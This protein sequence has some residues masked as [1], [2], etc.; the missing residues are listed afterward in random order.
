MAS[1]CC[2]LTTAS[3]TKRTGNYS[4]DSV[5]CS[6][7]PSPIVS[8]RSLRQETTISNKLATSTQ[9]PTRKACDPPA[10]LWCLSPFSIHVEAQ[11]RMAPAEHRG[12]RG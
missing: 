6:T 3:S 7:A 12:S 11:M 8:S 5:Q 2:G 10:W 9:S 4:T 1:S